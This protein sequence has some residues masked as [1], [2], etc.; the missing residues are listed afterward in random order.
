MKPV[1]ERRWRPEASGLEEV[2][3]RRLAQGFLHVATVDWST[4]EVVT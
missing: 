2:T 1:T 4:W 3:E